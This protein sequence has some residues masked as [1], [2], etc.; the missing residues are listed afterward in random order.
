MRNA[1]KKIPKKIDHEKEDQLRQEMERGDV[2]AMLLAAF[3]TLFLPAVILLL[4]L[5]GIGCLLF[6]GW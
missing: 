6:G 4:L 1:W 2:P 3:A 5:G